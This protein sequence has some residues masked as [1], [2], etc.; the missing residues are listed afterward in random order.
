M[1]VQ[2]A[3]T[4][5][6]FGMLVLIVGAVKVWAHCVGCWRAR[7]PAV[8]YEP[9]SPVPWDFGDLLV[10]LLIL[11]GTSVA[12]TLAMRWISPREQIAES[13]SASE[14]EHVEES[15]AVESDPRAAAEE[16]VKAEDQ[17]KGEEPRRLTARELP[18][19]TFDRLV[20][21]LLALLFVKFR[22]RATWSDLGFSIEHLWYDLRLGVLA[23]VAIG[24]VVYALQAL[25]QVI[26]PGKHPMIEMFADHPQP[27]VLALMV[28]LVVLVAPLT[29]EL[30]VRVLLQGW[31]ERFE[32]SCDA[33]SPLRR[34][35]L[36]LLPIL[37]SSFLFAV[38]H[39]GYGPDPVP[40]FLL[41]LALGYLY[42]RTHRIWP[43]V[44]MHM[45]L[46]GSSTVVLLLSLATGEL[47]AP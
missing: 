2:L 18:F 7:E 34:L 12:T 6:L 35:P 29:E 44:A 24:P 33:A 43:G 23:F 46:N 45:S 42:Q 14:S 30:I 8:P 10:V 26:F 22:S 41:A 47:P 20:A 36:G 13:Q 16:E 37:V 9:R 31:L 4:L 25:L 32:A 40:I 5:L 28:F 11:V 3:S 21:P 15:T 27:A 39:A 19:L 17:T 38:L 1:I